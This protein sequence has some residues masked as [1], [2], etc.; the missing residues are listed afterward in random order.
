MSDQNGGQG[1]C[2]DCVDQMI[3]QTGGLC[4]EC[5][6]QLTYAL[7]NRCPTCAEKENKCSLCDKKLR[8]EE[9]T[10][11]TESDESEDGDIL[12]AEHDEQEPEYDDDLD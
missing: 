6:K 10:S 1:L 2:E 12:L 9:E 11:A 7:Y 5:K 4:P 3:I 8:V